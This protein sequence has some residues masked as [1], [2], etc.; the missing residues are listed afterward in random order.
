[1]RQARVNTVDGR[2]CSRGPCL[3]PQKDSSR[4]TGWTRRW[5]GCTRTASGSILAT[6]TASPPPW[7]TLAHPDAMPVRPGR[8]AA[9]ARQPGHL[10]RRRARLPGGGPADHRRTGGNGTPSI[11]RSRC[12]TCTTSTARCAGAITRRRRSAAGCR[13]RYGPD[14]DGLAEAERGVGDRVLEPA[15]LVVG[16]GHAAAGHPVPAEPRA[17]ARLP[18]VLVRRTAGRLPSSSGTLLRSRTPGRAG[19]HELHGAGS[20]GASTRGRGGARWTWWRWTTTCRPP[21]LDGHADIAFVSD[22]A[23][24]VGGERPW[25]LMEQAP[26]TVTGPDGC[27][28]PGAGTDAPRQPGLRGARLGQRAVLPVAGVARRGGDVP[29]RR[30]CRTRGRIRGSSA[31]RSRWAPRWSGC[32]R[33][34]GA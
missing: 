25:L 30:W 18:A 6:P 5:T 34:P 33:S 11:R 12:G 7:F 23:R 19:H 20:P 24:G 15:V 14:A 29:L 1:M 16:A 17:V 10:L 21:G 27:T 9:L 8:V 13:A 28:T 22:W 32:R 26:G 2:A 3:S 31:R 4:S